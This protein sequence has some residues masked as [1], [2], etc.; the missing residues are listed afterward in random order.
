M[1]LGAKVR[2]HLVEMDPARITPAENDFVCV[3]VDE[4][5]VLAG[6]GEAQALRCS[7]AAE[8]LDF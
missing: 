8:G 2:L 7:A 1:R 6:L 4:I 5:E 3:S